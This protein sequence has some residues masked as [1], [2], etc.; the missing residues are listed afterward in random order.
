[1]MVIFSDMIERVLEIFMDDFS[2][3]GDSYE[4]CLENLRR[5]L[6]RCQEKKLVLNLEKCH[7]MVT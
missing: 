3:F 6:E 5:V 1:M 4:G 2:V 7:F